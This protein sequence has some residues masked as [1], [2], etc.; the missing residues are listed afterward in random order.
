[1]TGTLERFAA[2]TAVQ[3]AHS[4]RIEDL[5]PKGDAECLTRAIEYL[6]P[7]SDTYGSCPEAE[8]RELAGWRRNMFPKTGRKIPARAEQPPDY[9]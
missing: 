1:V 8:V 2:P 5:D 3:A 9:A 6:Q 4:D 7:F